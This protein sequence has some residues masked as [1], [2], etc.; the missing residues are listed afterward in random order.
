MSN[1]IIDDIT[2]FF[3]DNEFLGEPEEVP[4]EEVPAEEQ[5]DNEEPIKEEEE[6]EEE[7]TIPIPLEPVDIG[8]VPKALDR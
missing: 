2:N 5:N 6:I 7:E 8:E 3:S 1:N 4:I